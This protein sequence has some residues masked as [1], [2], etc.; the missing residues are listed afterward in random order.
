MNKELCMQHTHK[1]PT[2]AWPRARKLSRKQTSRAKRML[3]PRRQR[4]IWPHTAR[5]GALGWLDDDAG[6]MITHPVSGQ[7]CVTTH[8][9]VVGGEVDM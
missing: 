4:R 3:A 1:H 2:T 7:M 6:A 9:L 5:P 8:K